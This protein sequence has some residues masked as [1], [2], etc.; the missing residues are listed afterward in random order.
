MLKSMTAYSRASRMTPFGLLSCEIHSLNRRF[1]DLH[2]S[3]AKDIS[4]LDYP[5]R[6]YLSSKIARGG[7]S[8]SLHLRQENNN[9]L[10]VENLKRSKEHWEALA[11]SLG[12]QAEQVVSFQFLCDKLSSI[13]I[14]DGEF[15][16]AIEKEAMELVEQALADFIVMKRQEG[17]VLAKDIFAHLK[18]IEEMLTP[19][20]NLKKD[21]VARYRQKIEKN[22]AE[23]TQGEELDERI[24]REIA[25]YADRV[26]IHEEL[27]RLKS[28]I[29]RFN[30]ICQEKKN[31]CGKELD[32]IL[33]EM[34]REINT[35]GSKAS[36]LE[37]T[38]RVLSAK[39]DLEKIREQIQN[40]E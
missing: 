8:V 36:D 6:K 37:V 16:K 32:F 29:E 21:S 28:H 38:N 7:V 1:L 3:I 40:V 17:D 24:L 35:I 22:L 34:H 10:Q 12:Y 33:Q 39:S 14:G 26:D 15:E 31:S 25:I 11:K 20:V 27:T 23:F 4:F 18:K 13:P 30:Q 2:L 19:L 9:P 5:L